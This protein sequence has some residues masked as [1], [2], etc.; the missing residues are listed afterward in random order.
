M[1]FGDTMGDTTSIATVCMNVMHNK[2]KNLEVY[3]KH[4]N[5]AA[6]VGAKLVV[7][8]ESSLQGHFHNARELRIESIEYQYEN[9][10]E[11]PEGESTQELIEKAKEKDIYVIWG[12][13]ERSLKEGIDKLYNTAVLVGPEGYL[14]K[15]RKVHLAF[16]EKYV[17]NSGNGW[18]VY[19][20]RIGKIGML[21]CYDKAFP[22]PCREL[23]LQ[24]A[25]L[26]IM[27][28]A[29]PLSKSG[30]DP[31]VEE[32]CKTYLYD[33]FDKVRAAENQCWFISSNQVGISGDHD[34]LGH[35]RIV[36]PNGR[37]VSELGYE[38]GRVTASI[39]V[40]G[41]ILK[42]RT[43]EFP[44]VLKDRKPSTYLHIASNSE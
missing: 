32:D 6:K 34:Y 20:T 37:V 2:R 23:A 30:G 18:S 39:D 24:G 38:E 16:A 12:M 44:N 27:P 42:A 14:G 36:A 35:S 21:I 4:I 9:A 22:E 15:Y 31:N 26:L 41:A 8:P 17:F 1:N 33:L 43:I 13:A 7:F 11:V 25:E 40:R 3:M 5:E 29:W 10:E 28:T 19:E